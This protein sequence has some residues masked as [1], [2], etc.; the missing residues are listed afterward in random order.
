MPHYAR[1]DFRGPAWAVLA[2]KPQRVN[3]DEVLRLVAADSSISIREISRHTGISTRTPS[4]PGKKSCR[5][6][7]AY[8]EEWRCSHSSD[9]GA[10][11]PLLA[12]PHSVRAD[13]VAV[14]ADTHI[15]TRE[16]SCCVFYC[17][18]VW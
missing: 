7:L 4:T 2:R 15:S 14:I 6:S 5:I 1:E 3:P 18:H 12:T 13:I 9:V 10:D 16:Q 11:S 17:A 8:D